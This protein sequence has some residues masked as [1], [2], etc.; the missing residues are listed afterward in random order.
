METINNLP[1]QL[2]PKETNAIASR[3]VSAFNKETAQLVSM[4]KEVP[5]APPNLGTKVDLKA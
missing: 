2:A 4:G 3:P 5:I 1:P